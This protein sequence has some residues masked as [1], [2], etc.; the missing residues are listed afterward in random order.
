M[1]YKYL[2]IDLD[3]TVW[4]FAQNAEDTF[5]EIYEEFSYDQF[6]DSFEQFY[7]IYKLRNAELWQRYGA[8]KITKDELNQD[9]F[10]FP[11][12]QVGVQNSALSMAFSKRFFEEIRTKKKLMPHALEALAYLC[13]K[14]YSLH[15]LSNGFR[16]LQED[17]IKASGVLP[18]FQTLI[19]SEDIHVHKPF[20]EIFEYALKQAG[21]TAEHSIMIGDN[22][23]AD[24]F[25]AKRAGIDQLYYNYYQC[26][27]TTFKP[28][29]EVISW[30]EIR[31]IM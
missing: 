3:D 5:R 10:S 28:T 12:L 9:R 30:D 19:F 27:E 7:T 21:A 11:L 22:F 25:G 24:I 16:K 20:L 17:K 13:E 1:R 6:F 31:T 26:K 4:D 23:Q 15:V 18:Y 29:Y 8:G 2:F 14:G